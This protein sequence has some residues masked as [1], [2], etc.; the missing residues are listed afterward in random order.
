MATIIN[1]IDKT[2]QVQARWTSAPSNQPVP[3]T[4]TIKDNSNGTMDITVTWQT[5]VQGAVPAQAIGLFYEPSTTMPTKASAYIALTLDQTSYTFQGVDPT[6]TYRVGIAVGG[7][8]NIGLNIGTM[9]SPTSSP[10]WTVTALSQSNNTNTIN[11]VL[12]ATIT[13]SINN[14]NTQNDNDSSAITV[15]PTDV[16]LSHTTKSVGVVDLK[17][18]WSWAGTEGDIDG[19]GIVVHT[20]ATNASYTL[21]QPDDTIYQVNAHARAFTGLGV[22]ADQWYTVG[23]IPYRAV[24]KAVNATGVIAGTLVPVA[25]YRPNA[26]PNITANIGGMPASTVIANITN[27]NTLNDYDASAITISCTNVT[28][29]STAKSLGTVDMKV[30]WEWAGTEGDIDGFGIVVHIDS[31]RTSSGAAN[32]TNNKFLKAS[33]GTLISYT[34]VPATPLEDTVYQ[35]PA[36]KR[37]FILYGLN[38]DQYYTIG[39]VPFRAVA[40]SVNAAGIILGYTIQATLNQPTPTPNITASIN[41]VP[42]ATLTGNTATS[43]AFTASMLN[44]SILTGGAQKS[45]VRTL[46]NNIVTEY[47]NI[48]TQ[49][50]A[51][52]IAYSLMATAAQNFANYLNLGVTW[53]SGYPTSIG[54]VALSSDSSLSIETIRRLAASYVAEKVLVLNAM[55]AKAATTAVM[56]SVTGQATSAQIAD[57]AITNAKLIT[58]AVTTIKLASN[59]VTAS[60]TSLAAINAS[61]GNL[62]ANTVTAS[63]IVAGSIVGS[64]IAAG[65]I[66][67]DKITVSTLSA[68]TANL[69][70]VNAGTISGAL[71]LNIGGQAVF[72]GYSSGSGYQA[73]ITSNNAETYAYG[74]VSKGTVRGVLGMTSTYSGIGVKGSNGYSGA[75]T[76]YGV[77]GYSI[78]SVGVGAE[79]AYGVALEV[80]GKARFSSED[81]LINNK[82]IVLSNSNTLAFGQATSGTSAAVARIPIYIDGNLYYINLGV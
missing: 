67:S 52:G 14:F 22:A 74:L 9:V 80:I 61:T 73:T 47:T 69:G 8:T 3:L 51:Q 25:A 23:I 81:T 39:V 30:T 13:S 75:N 27:F 11:G 34:P 59:A 36:Y 76:G 62:N 55:T 18:V 63:T 40:K 66:T 12:A 45:E 46:W 77:S 57:N 78:Y 5:Y 68:F 35:T 58:D 29:T 17:V 56:T 6:T 15:V 10:N 53:V 20:G 43:F 71:D 65:T 79:S 28:L 42:A 7:A 48:L 82:K 19:F 37:D 38:P 50:V 60:K 44:D 31:T 2:L 49:A 33:N 24:N 54:D 32:T 4:L 64:N 41:N 16:A 26:T 70:T 21:G 72:T 1:E